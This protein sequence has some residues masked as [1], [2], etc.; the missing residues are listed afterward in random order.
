VFT[1]PVAVLALFAAVGRLP[2][3]VENGLSKTLATLRHLD[4]FNLPSWKT[5]QQACKCE[6]GKDGD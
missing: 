2:A 5:H 6:V 1:H 3:A 4:N